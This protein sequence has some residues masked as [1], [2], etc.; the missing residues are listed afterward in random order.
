[1]GYSEGRGGVIGDNGRNKSSEGGV[2][3]S[4]EHFSF[5]FL[6]GPISSE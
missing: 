6:N 5:L 1:M 2:A 4:D 3:V